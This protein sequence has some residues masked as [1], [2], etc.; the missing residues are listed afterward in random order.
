MRQGLDTPSGYS[1]QREVQL[2]LAGKIEMEGR[3]RPFQEACTGRKAPGNE[4]PGR[5]AAVKR[6]EGNEETLLEVLY[7]SDTQGI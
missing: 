7:L 4:K 2:H 1:P 6:P 5:R 3:T